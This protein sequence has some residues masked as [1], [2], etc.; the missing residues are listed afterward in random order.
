MILFLIT[1]FH[2]IT[3][4]SFRAKAIKS[5]T[6][7][8]LV[9]LDQDGVPLLVQKLELISLNKD[10]AF[11]ITLFNGK[12]FNTDWNNVARH[13]SSLCST[14]RSK[15]KPLTENEWREVEKAITKIAEGNWQKLNGKVPV[16]N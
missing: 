12:H 13:S 1:F 11:L 15:N 16:L 7:P 8:M 14:R 2:W 9:R 4:E 6:A 3:S 10:E 5:V